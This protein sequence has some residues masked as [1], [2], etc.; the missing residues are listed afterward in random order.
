MQT[1]TEKK[2]Y[3]ED[4]VNA[5]IAVTDDTEHGSDYININTLGNDKSSEWFGKI[6]LTLNKKE[7][8]ALAEAILY[9]ID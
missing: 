4:E 6:D 8:K 2:L 9:F 3:V 5:F 1:F 7:A